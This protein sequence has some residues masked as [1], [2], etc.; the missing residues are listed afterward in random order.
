MRLIRGWMC[1]LGALHCTIRVGQRPLTLKPP[2]AGLSVFLSETGFQSAALRRNV[3]FATCHTSLRRPLTDQPVIDP[4][5]T[6]MTTPVS[7]RTLENPLHSLEQDLSRLLT[8]HG[9]SL[10]V[11]YTYFRLYPLQTSRVC[12]YNVI[13]PYNYM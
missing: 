13:C 11:R 5:A 12:M 1:P 4:P 9:R 7:L 8:C 3:P 2:R 10:K 6:V